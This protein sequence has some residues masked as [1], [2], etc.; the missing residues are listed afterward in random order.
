MPRIFTNRIPVTEDAIDVNQHVNN[1]AYLRWM[2]DAATD[3]SAAQG[4]TFERYVASG[5]GWF[6]RSHFI[7]YLHPAFAGDVLK[8]HTWVHAID[9]RSS[10]RHYCFVRECDGEIIA[11]AETLW[12]FVNFKTGRPSRIP[13][14]VAS[15][16][17]I[18]PQDDPELLSLTTK[19]RRET[20]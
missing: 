15:A 1:L 20:A 2:Q 5:A 9:S 11:K 4:W 19:Q 8:L 6:V 17:A 10:P 13:P 16:F 14:E 18:V 3:H 12:V 7:E